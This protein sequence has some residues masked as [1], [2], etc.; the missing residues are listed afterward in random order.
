MNVRAAAAKTLSPILKEEAS[1]QS[2]FD[3][4]AEKIPAQDR[5]LFH[6]LVYGCL[7][8]Y[9]WL[10]FISQQLLSKKLKNK[11]SDVKALILLGIYQLELM[12]TP[13]HAAISETVQAAVKLK[14]PW[15]KNLVNAVL[16]NFVRER[17][18][19]LNKTANSDE[20]QH[21]CPQWLLETL[22]QDWPK[23][24]PTI[25]A[26]M[27]EQAP[28][29]LR[30]N[31]LR[32]NREQ[33][34]ELLSKSDIDCQPTSYSNVGI[35]SSSPKVFE[36]DC[37]K[38]GCFSVQ[39]EAAQLSAS[40]L[41]LEAGQRVLDAC[42]AP[43]GKSTH[44][45]EQ[46][47]ELKQLVSLE[48][49]AKRAERMQQNFER[50]KLQ[51]RATIQVAD[52][53]NLNQWWD[54]QPFDRI[55]LDAPCS[56]SGIIRRHP[57]IKRLRRSDDPAQLSSLQ[58]QLLKQLWQCLKPGGILLYATCSIFKREN[59]QQIAQF[60]QTQK[61]AK[62]LEINATWGEKRSFGRQLFPT[63]GAHDGFYYAC[64]IKDQEI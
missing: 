29:T 15:A 13:D 51:Q 53:A 8:H 39:D 56:A 36:L 55:L 27:A 17:D 21:N 43:G 30:T 60:L 62:H 64:L 9:E 44:I 58:E 1:L 5:A 20:A 32:Q 52:A 11:D 35:I 46:Q 24:W 54:K 25:V 40:L 45:L 2:H 7:R 41:Q 12:R 16:R 26:A 48:I 50:L 63:K 61:D 59:E 34:Q 49:D 33:L 19:I 37:F 3:D 4:A 10:D 18:N 31:T 6:T 28:L 23:T 22:K 14:K 47:P 57:D 42:A 38:D